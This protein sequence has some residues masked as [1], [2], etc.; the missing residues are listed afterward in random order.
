MNAYTKITGAVIAGVLLS[1]AASQAQIDLTGG[2]VVGTLTSELFGISPGYNSLANNGS[3]TSW[4]VQGA[5]IDPSGLIFVYQVSN[6]GQSVVPNLINN[7]DINGFSSSFIVGSPG[8]YGSITGLSIGTTPS[9]SGNFGT[10]LLG[11]D[12]VTF[13]QTAGLQGVSD[14]LV[15]ETDATAF[16]DSYSQVAGSLNTTGGAFAAQ[17]PT[18]APVPEA[19]TMFAGALMLLPLGIGAIRALRKQRTA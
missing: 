14:Y 11:N 12:N 7:V 15:I 2:H 1:S 17:G 16:G 5:T 18:T 9:A 6:N 4:V 8:S 13:Q 10:V 19:N 3:I